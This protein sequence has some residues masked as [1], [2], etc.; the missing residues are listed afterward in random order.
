M[1]GLQAKLKEVTTAKAWQSLIVCLHKERDQ[2]KEEIAELRSK[3]YQ[4]PYRSDGYSCASDR[5]LRPRPVSCH[6][7]SGTQTHRFASDVR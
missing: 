3:V 1:K 4:L 7:Q 5:V 6:A 2:L